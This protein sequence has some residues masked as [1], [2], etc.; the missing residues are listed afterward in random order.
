M[1]QAAS[2]AASLH[3]RRGEGSGGAIA[4]GAGSGG[5]APSSSPRWQPGQETPPPHQPRIQLLGPQGNGLAVTA[6]I[7]A[8]CSARC[9]SSSDTW[10]TNPTKRD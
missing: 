8:A 4:R 6:G 5:S 7:A 9:V 3:G 10:Y 1:A 2:I